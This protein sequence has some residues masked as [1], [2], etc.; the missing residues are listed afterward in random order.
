VQQ[1]LLVRRFISRGIIG[2]HDQFTAIAKLSLQV[3]PLRQFEWK[4]NDKIEP[5]EL[6][7]G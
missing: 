6:D 3:M 7:L 4:N 1:V 5:P 2:I